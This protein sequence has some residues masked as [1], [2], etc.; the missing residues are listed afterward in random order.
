MSR[1]LRM[2]LLGAAMAW[3][4]AVTVP[5]I[6]PVPA[7]AATASKAEFVEKAG[8]AGLF[9]IESSRVALKKSQDSDVKAFAEKMIADH[10]AAGEAL[11]AAAKGNVPAAL[12][13]DHTK[14]LGQLTEASTDDFDRLYVE[15]Q[16]DGHAD[17][18][19][20]FAGYAESGDDPSLKAF[21]EKTLPTL[22]R[23]H[24][25]IEAI[26]STHLK[27]AS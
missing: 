2:V 3:P 22:K 8:L 7:V 21:A 9:E 23:H 20:L 11:K 1:Y 27:K 15:M 18:V 12:D 26:A 14:L 6:H 13:A 17:A 5:V 19:A 4:A 24:Q 16:L 25:M 10:T